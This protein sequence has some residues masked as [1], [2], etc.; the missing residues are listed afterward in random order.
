[1]NYET[2]YM[3]LF[4]GMLLFHECNSFD[5]EREVRLVRWFEWKKKAGPRGEEFDGETVD[6]PGIYC[7]SIWRS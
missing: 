1:M 5:H 3:R 7:P 6:G 4:G 2:D